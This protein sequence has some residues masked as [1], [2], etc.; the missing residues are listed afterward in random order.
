MECDILGGGTMGNENIKDKKIE[1]LNTTHKEIVQSTERINEI[2][3]KFDNALK[4]FEKNMNEKLVE[5]LDNQT[6]QI[7]DAIEN[8]QIQLIDVIDGEK[9]KISEYFKMLH[10]QIQTETEKQKK[11]FNE[12]TALI[13]DLKNLPTIKSTVNNLE[14]KIA[15]QAQQ[16]EEL[17]RLTIS[18]HNLIKS[19]IK[20]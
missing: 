5:K 2:N 11:I 1:T 4:Y 19:F 15:L 18:L 13:Q 20:E 17:K 12:T 16:L 8:Q 14:N 6:I 10:T 7:S 9:N 3:I